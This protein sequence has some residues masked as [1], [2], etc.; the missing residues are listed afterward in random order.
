MRQMLIALVTG[1]VLVS[2]SLLPAQETGLVV[3]FTDNSLAGWGG[4]AD[5]DLAV[6]NNELR[7]DANKRSTWNSFTFSFATLD[8][9]ANPYVSLKIKTDTNLNLGFSVWDVDDN[10]AYTDDVY[11]EIVVSNYFI[12]YTFDFSTIAGV[13]L[14]KI[15][16]LN[17][18]CNP[19]GAM[20]YN[21]MIWIDD[22]KIGS[23]AQ[24]APYITTI[25]KQFHYINSSQVTVPFRGVADIKAGE[26]PLAITATSSN[27]ALVENPVVNYTSGNAAGTLTY[28]PVANQSGLVTIT[29]TVTGNG[30]D[31]KL[32]LFDV[33]I[34]NNKAPTIDQ[35]ADYN[36]KQGVATEI[37]LTGIDDGN[38]NA[39][40]SLVITAT[41]AN[42]AIIPTPIVQYTN[43]ESSAHLLFTPA[44]AVS[45]PVQINI[46]LHDD[47]GQLNGGVDSSI[48]TFTVN[49]YDNVNNPPSL[50]EITH[51]S[52]LEGAVEHTVLLSGIADGDADVVQNLVITAASSNI[53]L[54]PNPVVEYV[55]GDSTA[56]LKYIPKAGVT[57]SV[58]IT[59]TVTDDGGAPANNGNESFTR[60]FNIQIRVKPI[61]GFSDEFEDGMLAPEWPADWGDPGENTHRC[62][63]SNGEIKIEIDKTR[64][65]NR[66]A[67]LWYNIPQELDLTLYPYIS[68]TM[69]TSVP[70]TQMLI[71]LWDAFDHYNTG[72]TVTHTVTGE[73]VEY[74]FDFSDLNLQGD[75]T[76][77]D[78]SRI[79]ALLINFD[80][81]GDS[82]LFVGDFYFADFRV[83]ELA[84]TIAKTPTVTLNAVPDQVVIKDAGEQTIQL[85]GISDG[86]NNSQPVTLEVQSSHKNIIPVP[87][88]SPVVNGQATLSYTPVAGKTGNS[89]IT[90]TALAPGS[91]QLTMCF[92][93]NIVDADT[94]VAVDVVIDVNQEYQVIDGFGTFMGSD[95]TPINKTHLA[96]AKDLGMTMARYGVIDK[97][98][99]PNNENSDP[100]ITDLNSYNKQALALENIKL[101]QAN[102]SVVKNIY[103]MWTPPAWMKRN[104]SLSAESW[105]TDNKLEE[106][107]YEEYAEHM[108]ALIRTIKNE[109]GV[110]LDAISLQNEPQFN[111]P[112]GSC[113]VDP[114]EMR[115]LIRI[116][117][118]RLDA[119]GLDTKIFWAEALPA[120]GM[121]DTYINAVKNDPIAKLYGDIVAI[122][123]Y[124]ADGIN[125]GGAGAEEWARIY[126]WAQQSEP[127]CPT[128]M[129]ETSGHANTWNGALE[130]AG[131]IYN[132]LAF[133]NASAWVYWSF[134]VNKD[135]E[136]F[137]LVVDNEPCCK[138]FVSKQYYKYIRPGAIRVN[139]TFSD[140]EV[141]CIA[142]KHNQEKTLTLVLLNKSD[143]PKVV[144]ISGANLPES[145][146]S[147]TTAENRNFTRGA[148]IPGGGVILLPGS[149]ITTL[150]GYYENPVSVEAKEGV[151]QTFALYQNFPNPFNPITTIY[152]QLPITTNL[153]IKIYDILGREVRSLVDRSFVAG[154]YK[155]IWDGLDNTGSKVA[156]GMYFYRLQSQ[157]YSAVKK[158]LL[159]K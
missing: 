92:K 132:A 104:K 117:G 14:T 147:Y 8:I 85:D 140:A 18:V 63:E 89:T 129:T 86:N 61:M 73:Y 39:E 138:F 101:L 38:P 52:I 90:I 136:V 82:P 118:P 29:V 144:Q 157:E 23:E 110:E 134:A 12:E 57:G 55:Q 69:K 127:V 46:V 91:N 155:I 107:Y 21:G 146:A 13:D 120:Q 77:V 145:F 112:Y 78:F 7:I 28:A 22:L 65:G 10:Y 33:Q 51:I 150:V 115:D 35:A 137:G 83:G 130:L 3:D 42:G 53:T 114:N 128:W 5:Y 58:T 70:G 95:N 47:G 152:F 40:Q 16:M 99:E 97:E 68:I 24:V 143:D 149:S 6:V 54:V 32:V 126:E 100:N 113:Q 131:N 156:T 2:V 123:N 105:A 148:E 75:G 116:V 80:P 119:E 50:D 98:F 4:T 122:H 43:G 9:S 19:G 102:T 76:I 158:C 139:V 124:D 27:P 67:G 109:T 64:T 135:S 17:F 25:P 20:I 133:G 36:A 125:V 31:S 79:K 56:V 151:P 44:L 37:L 94:A 30:A 26:N 88:V 1:F 60:T 142:F 74:Y 96:L 62:N 11:Q 111:E 153:S 81:G 41:S 103:T 154:S 34:E 108:V 71:F 121:I 72:G 93:I 141:P 106:F 159:L 48:M 49:V 59:V 45:G 87:V 84:H 15:K 66:W